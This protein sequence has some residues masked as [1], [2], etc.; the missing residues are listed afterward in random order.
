[1]EFEI[2]RIP[3][4][5][6]DLDVSANAELF[7][8]NQNHCVLEEP[9][10]VKGELKLYKKEIYFK[11]EAKANLRLSCSRCLAPYQFLAETKVF[12]RFIPKPSANELDMERQMLEEEIDAEFYTDSKINIAASIRDAIMLALP[13]IQLCKKDCLGLCSDCGKNLNESQCKCGDNTAIDPRFEKLKQLKDK[14]QQKEN[15]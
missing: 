15:S 5:G 13:M 8:I 14:L 4:S 1:M 6:F 2:D 11:G 9:V 12:A 7:E 10:A 3:S